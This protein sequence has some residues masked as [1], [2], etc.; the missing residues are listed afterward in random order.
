MFF[1][2]LH[3]VNETS[4]MV[5]HYNPEQG[6]IETLVMRLMCCTCPPNRL[7]LGVMRMYAECEVGEGKKGKS[8][9]TRQMLCSCTDIFELLSSW[10]VVS[11]ASITQ[12]A[13]Q[14]S[15]ARYL[16]KVLVKDAC[17]EK[18]S[19][20]LIEKV[21][22]HNNEWVPNNDWQVPNDKNQCL[23]VMNLCLIISK[24]A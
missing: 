18:F 11:P 9:G 23:I 2:S 3:C 1:T 17:P 4:H 20:C 6:R 10:R 24:Q 13:T 21:G 14:H 7:F 22:P 15:S 19:W 8:V 12:L 5:N 16:R